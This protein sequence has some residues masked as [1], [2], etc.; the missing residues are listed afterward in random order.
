M[1]DLAIPEISLGRLSSLVSLSLI[2]AVV[3]MV[4]TAATTRSFLSN[5]D[6]PA[7]VNRDFIGVGAGSLLS[8]LIG[9]FPVDA[10]PPRTAVV[11]DPSGPSQ[12][13]RLLPVPILTAFLA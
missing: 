1:R 10:S 6:E 12:L 13:A 3:V 9:A 7:D 4:Q 11:S 8:G 2:I 5:P